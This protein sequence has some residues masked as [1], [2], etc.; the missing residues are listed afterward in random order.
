MG[1]ADDVAER[2]YYETVFKENPEKALLREKSQ[3]GSVERSVILISPV[4]EYDQLIQVM[5]N[6]R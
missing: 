1:G 3:M 2:L 6:S 5:E 4:F